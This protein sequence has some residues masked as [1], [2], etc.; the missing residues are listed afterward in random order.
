[1]IE[2]VIEKSG[3]KITNESFKQCWLDLSLIPPTGD[4]L[5][6]FGDK[7]R[8]YEEFRNY[9][10]KFGTDKLTNTMVMRFIVC[11][12]DPNSPFESITDYHK[13]KLMSAEFAG[14]DIGNT[15]IF[16]EY[17]QMLMQGKMPIANAMI[18]CYCLIVHSPDYATYQLFQRKYYE[19]TLMDPKKKLTD[20]RQELNILNDF[21][22]NI[23][24]HDLTPDIQR[25]YY[26]TVTNAELEVRKYRPETKAEEWVKEFKE[27][28]GSN[29]EETGKK[30]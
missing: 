16:A 18:I 1:M 11:M 29:K 7:L 26:R 21:R 19:D 5:K 3:I 2:S 20:I 30:K 25:D 27:K 22:N 4:V 12:Y 8:P 14:F 23:L 24:A 9:E 6:V 13:R 15:G 28:Y 10:G 17:A